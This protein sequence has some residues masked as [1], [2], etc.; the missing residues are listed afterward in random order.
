[1]KTP[2]KGIP[3]DIR[4]NAQRV[5]TSIADKV[6]DFM[7]V[8]QPRKRDANVWKF[9]WNNVKR[10]WKERWKYKELYNMSTFGFLAKK[11]VSVACRVGEHEK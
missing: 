2:V 6:F 9:R 4:E 1:L 11:V 7:F 10:V 3:I 5:D 8:G